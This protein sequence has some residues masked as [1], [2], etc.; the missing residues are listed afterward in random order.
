MLVLERVR[1]LFSTDAAEALAAYDPIHAIAAALDP[2]QI[3]GRH[4]LDKAQYTWTKTMLECQILS[5]GG[6]RVDMAHSV[7][8]RPPFLD[9]RLAEIARTVPPK[10]RI[11]NGV[12][13]W[14]LREAMRGVLPEV[15]YKREK[16]AFMA[17]PAAT[18]PEKRKGVRALIDAR[19]Q[20][21]QIDA[22]GLFDRES[23][24]AFVSE[25]LLDRDAVGARRNDIIM[26]H[27]LG[28]HVIHQDLVAGSP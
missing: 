15:L 9:H 19:L 12:E 1:P 13:K 6:D 3:R 21:E 26:N 20:P 25:Y 2:A 8:S 14:V 17:P 28:L 27:L 22:L 16:F 5:W 7:E 4:P 23:V 18:D 24:A 10:L 11:K